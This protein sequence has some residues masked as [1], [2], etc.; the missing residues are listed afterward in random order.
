MAQHS[1]QNISDAV[2]RLRRAYD[3]GNVELADRGGAR[4]QA[5]A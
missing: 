2:Q 1:P 4:A 5:A 3:M